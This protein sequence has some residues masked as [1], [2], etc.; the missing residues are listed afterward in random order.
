MTKEEPSSRIIDNWFEVDDRLGNGVTSISEPYHD[1]E[2]FCYL[3][4]GSDADLLVDTGMGIGRIKQVLDF[5]H[6]RNKKLMVVNTHA[7]FDHIG[8]NSAFDHVLT[9][10]N[11]W[12]T[13]NIRKGWDHE[14]MVTE[15]VISEFTDKLPPAFD[16]GAYAVSGYASINPVL[17]DSYI[18]NLGNRIFHCLN[19]PGH[20]P[21]GIC[22]LE[23]KTGLLFT[24][25]L[26][27]QGPLYC[28]AEESSLQDYY[29]SLKRVQAVKKNIAVILPG[30]NYNHASPHLIDFAIECFDRALDNSLPDSSNL[31]YQEYRH[32]FMP[33]LGVRIKGS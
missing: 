5:Y 23:E 19:T 22:L 2:V 13:Q 26:L 10:A 24:S 17:T 14:Y 30:H 1:E 16:P 28:Y 20:T 15:G 12:E 9:P 29:A 4:K 18:L 6:R 31:V 3:V 32:P 21:G 11:D 8:G 33:R 27:Y 7:H 25:D